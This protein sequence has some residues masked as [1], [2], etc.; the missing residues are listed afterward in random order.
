MPLLAIVYTSALLSSNFAMEN[1]LKVGKTFGAT[2]NQVLL[3][4]LDNNL[5][6]AY[7]F[8]NIFM[9]PEKH[10]IHMKKKKI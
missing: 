1:T 2:Y 9:S 7:T 4:C 5:S 3:F 8:L 6:K 10:G